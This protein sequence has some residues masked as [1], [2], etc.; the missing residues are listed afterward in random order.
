MS[1]VTKKTSNFF[2]LGMS[3]KLDIN[4][5]LS[6]IHLFLTYAVCCEQ[7]KSGKT[8]FSFSKRAFD[9]IFRSTFN[10]EMGLQFFM[11]LLSLSFF[12][13]T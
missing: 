11:N 12:L 13:L 7:I 9:I 10:K 6:P 5:P 4:L 8:F 3:I 2:I 1:I